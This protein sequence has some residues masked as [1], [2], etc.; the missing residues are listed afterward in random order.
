[1]NSTIALL[2]P[3]QTP[4]ESVP[5]S[6][7][8]NSDFLPAFE[9]AIETAKNEVDLICNTQGEPNFENTIE[10]LEFSGERLA[11]ISNVFFNLN[12][13]ETNDELQ[14]LAREISPKLSAFNND[15]LL[16]ER[17][18]ERIQSVWNKR[19]S[20]QLPEDAF[21]LLEK[22]YL[23]FLRNGA[24]LNAQD[25]TKLRQQDEELSKLSL[26][27]GENVLAETNAFLKVLDDESLLAGLPKS[28]CDAAHELAAE[29]GKKRMGI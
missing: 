27:F 12:S 22:T 3:F 1:M 14:G 6:K 5:F 20:L 9:K 26:Q 17:L 16:N 4:F 7:I 29:K 23:R 8:K 13:A 2:E 28:A 11:V 24:K 21:T 25:K 15:I 19:Q 10:A 18:F